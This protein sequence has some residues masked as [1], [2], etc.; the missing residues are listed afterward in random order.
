MVLIPVAWIM[1]VEPSQ[2]SIVARLIG[3][4]VTLNELIAYKQLGEIKKSG[5]LSV[6]HKIILFYTTK[7]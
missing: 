6:R 1:G 7:V 4:K 2:C 5:V 3:V